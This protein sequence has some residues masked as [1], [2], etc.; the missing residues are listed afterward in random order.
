MNN[1]IDIYIVERNKTVPVACDICHTMLQ[2]LDDAM[3]AYNNGG[4][5]DCFISFLEPNRS[6]KG[7]EWEPSE[8]EIKGWLQNK[9]V[10]FK[11][12]YKFF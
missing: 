9:K 11:P 3:C 2:S 7:A 6:M 5:R 1:F 4:C 10:R 8:A 12:M